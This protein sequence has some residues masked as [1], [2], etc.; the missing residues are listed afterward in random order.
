M[1]L[2]SKETINKVKSENEERKEKYAGDKRPYI[3]AGERILHLSNVELKNSKKTNDSMLVIELSED[4]DKRPLIE[5]Y[6]LTGNGAGIGQEKAVSFLINAFGHEIPVCETEM[7]VLKEFLKFKGKQFKAA[8]KI[9]EK[10]YEYTTQDGNKGM[11]IQKQPQ[12]WYTGKIDD[13][14]F[15]VKLDKIVEELSSEDKHKFIEYQK[16][17]PADNESQ[18]DQEKETPDNLPF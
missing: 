16:N 9:K 8:V 14:G 1:S 7:D 18:V 12:L 17:K 13:N 5:N 2:L 11:T 6:M 15:R 10:L 4:K 3:Q